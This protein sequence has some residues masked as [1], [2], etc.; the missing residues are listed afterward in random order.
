MC[1]HDTEQVQCTIDVVSPAQETQCNLTY[2]KDTLPWT[3]SAQCDINDTYSGMG[4]YFCQLFARNMNVTNSSDEAVDSRVSMK[5]TS[6]PGQK[7]VSGSCFMNATL[8]SSDG[9]Y[10]YSVQITPGNGTVTVSTNDTLIE[11]QR[12]SLSKLTHSC[13]SSISERD[14]LNCTCSYEGTSIP[15]S[16]V[17]WSG[18]RS[19]HLQRGPVKRDQNGHNFTCQL[20]WNTKVFDQ[21]TYTLNVSWSPDSNNVN[22]T[23]PAC[24]TEASSTDGSLGLTYTHILAIGIGGGLSVTA[25]CVTIIVVVVVCRKR[26]GVPQNRLRSEQRDE[27]GPC[28]RLQALS[29]PSNAPPGIEDLARVE[30]ARVGYDA[31]RKE[32]N[33]DGQNYEVMDMPTVANPKLSQSA[34]NS[35]SR[36]TNSNIYGNL[37]ARCADVMNDNVMYGNI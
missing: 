29:R 37:E 30:Q 18:E 6:L 26:R 20:M 22:Y 17:Q 5:N 16:T 2:V 13:P 36:P 32:E 25:I 10:S 15:P 35:S 24:V 21:L 34:P 7:L 27:S 11:I 33:L 12:P 4:R 19:R 14:P 8:P 28:P 3:L 31:L 23:C 1:R 9:I